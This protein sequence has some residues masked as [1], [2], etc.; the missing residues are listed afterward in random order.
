MRAKP[1]SSCRNTPD[2]VETSS[3]TLEYKDGAQSKETITINLGKNVT[4]KE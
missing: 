3:G 1:S 4:T 2:K